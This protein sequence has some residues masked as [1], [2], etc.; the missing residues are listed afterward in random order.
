MTIWIYFS[1][2][3]L[4]ERV[5]SGL[6]FYYDFTVIEPDNTVK[7]TQDSNGDVITLCE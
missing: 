2:C 3:L 5:H 7:N 1:F 6:D 4:V